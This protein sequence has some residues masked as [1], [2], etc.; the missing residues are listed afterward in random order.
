M[1]DIIE[2]TNNLAA[3]GT[4]FEFW[5]RRTAPK[6]NVTLIL[7]N[8][9]PPV[10]EIP[11]KRDITITALES[12]NPIVEIPRRKRNLEIIIWSYLKSLE[13][14]T[15]PS[16]MALFDTLVEAGV[17]TLGSY[18][19]GGHNRE[20]ARKEAGR[21]VEYKPTREID[22]NCKSKR[23]C[24]VIEVYESPKTKVNKSG[25]SGKYIN[26]LKPLIVK[27]D[28]FQGTKAELFDSWGLYDPYKGIGIAV[29]TTH[30]FNPWRVPYNA[31]LGDEAYRRAMNYQE[32]E[33]LERA[34]NSLQKE[35]I[36]T[37]RKPLKYSP[38]IETDGENDSSDRAQSCQEWENIHQN[39]LKLIQQTA[40][41]EGCALEPELYAAAFEPDMYER[42]KDDY[43][44]NKNKPM[45]YTATPE[46]QAW[47]ENYCLFLRQSA[48]T[49]CAEEEK[50]KGKGVQG[51]QK[52]PDSQDTKDGQEK[53]EKYIALEKLPDLH[54][55][56]SNP[57]YAK[58]YIRLDKHW[59]G[60]LLGWR[61][62]WKEYE[63]EII[64]HQAAEQ[65]KVE[66]TA[67]EIEAL[68]A[69]FLKYMDGQMLHVKLDTKDLREEED[70]QE[71]GEIPAQKVTL[72]SSNSARDLHRKLKGTQH[73]VPIEILTSSE[74]E[75]TT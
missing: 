74:V 12:P 54:D 40:E 14:Q 62:V 59:K 47:Y 31:S 72:H 55:F 37:W 45:V 13:D 15:F 46:Q 4:S 24:T 30:A 36:L 21:Y 19:S 5:G 23:Q 49:E 71:L 1:E 73:K 20:V 44:I 52:K 32:K 35:G 38:R 61:S 8:P 2:L 58:K 26:H 53:K 3:T 18:R 33:C 16:E 42:Y 39:R 34:L 41:I 17:S 9:P 6:R 67:K 68:R 70:L 43:Y 63:Y 29:E 50:E 60:Q 7:L 64:N 28:T 57:R 48:V 25:K 22:P 75:E 65:Y 56:W 11:R 66:D 51:G 10:I 27:H 69:E